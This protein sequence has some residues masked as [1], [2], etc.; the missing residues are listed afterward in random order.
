MRPFLD[1][2]GP[3][4]GRRGDRVRYEYIVR[5]VNERVRLIRVGKLPTFN[6]RTD[7]KEYLQMLFDRIRFQDFGDSES[8]KKLNLRQ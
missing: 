8:S 1:S 7:P 6:N 3:R 4:I 2:Y 5:Y